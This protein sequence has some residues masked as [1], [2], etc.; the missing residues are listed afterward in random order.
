M[1]N[2]I[3]N[4]FE[5]GLIVSCQAEGDDPFNNKES[6]VR[7]AIAAQMGGAV[8]I[9]SEGIENI[10][11]IK[12][13]LNLPI[14]GLIK[15]TFPD[16]FVKITGSINELEKLIKVGSDIVAI[17]GTFRSREGMTGPQFINFVKKNYNCIVLAD[18]ST[19]E[20]AI[21]CQNSGADAIATTLNGY[22]PETIG[23]NNGLPNYNLISTIVK[24]LNI[25]V[26]AEGR[27]SEPG[28]LKKIL[29]LGAF[30]VVV[31]TAITRP[32][33]ITQKFVNNLK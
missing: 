20:E 3:F 30:S 1:K 2:K 17:D 33:I 10:S 21:E 9:R 19:L 23:D 28:Q 4:R 8:G 18:I 25:P 27:I 31:G 12:K 5:K 26:F 22:T 6:I 24:N 11:A 7:F 16:K 29:E 15:S 13:A 32:R 14:I